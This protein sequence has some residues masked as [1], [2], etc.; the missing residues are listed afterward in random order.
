MRASRLEYGG[1]R[2]NWLSSLRGFIARGVT[3]EAMAVFL[4]GE[5]NEDMPRKMGEGLCQW[6][7]TEREHAYRA[8]APTEDRMTQDQTINALAAI[9][10]A[11]CP[12]APTRN[13]LVIAI[14]EGRDALTWPVWTEPIRSGELEAAL[15]CGWTWPTMHSERKRSE[16]YYR[17]LQGRLGE[18]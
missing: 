11:S 18:P 16:K 1:G 2:I 5:R 6:D 17:F 12:S 13:G 10:L 8:K 14:A 7:P 3:P 15:C 4:R 9:G